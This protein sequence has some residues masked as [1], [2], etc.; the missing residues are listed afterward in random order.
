M[1]YKETEKLIEKYIGSETGTHEAHGQIVH[2]YFT[3]CDFSIDFVSACLLKQGFKA[4]KTNNNYTRELWSE[5]YL[6][7]VSYCEGDFYIVQ[8]DNIEAFNIGKQI[9]IEFYQNN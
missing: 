4:I 3:G 6:S 7:N 9:A 1:N 8:Y 2:R 5:E